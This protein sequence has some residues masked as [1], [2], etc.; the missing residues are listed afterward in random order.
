MISNRSVWG[1]TYQ[2][3]EAMRS[4]WVF[5]S[6]ASGGSPSRA[7]LSMPPAK[8]TNMVDNQHDMGCFREK[9]SAPATTGSRIR[10]QE[11]RTCRAAYDYP[12][13]W[14]PT[15]VP[16]SYNLLAEPTWYSYWGRYVTWTEVVAHVKRAQHAMGH[17]EIRVHLPFRHLAG[18]L[19]KRF[20]VHFRF[21]PVFRYAVV[22]VVTE[23]SPGKVKSETFLP[24]PRK[25]PR[26]SSQP[27]SSSTPRPVFAAEIIIALCPGEF[28]GVKIKRTTHGRRCSAEDLPW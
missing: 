22:V 24:D 13:A 5:L 7:A 15:T 17:V 18:E 21:A 3:A 26:S 2:T 16:T 1:V 14:V 20:G 10:H 8:T 4:C 11:P 23:F 25:E 9:A 27:E 19:Q 28:F 6:G 12:Y